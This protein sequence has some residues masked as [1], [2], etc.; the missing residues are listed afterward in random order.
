LSPL[1]NVTTIGDEFL[2]YCRGLNYVNLRGLSNVITIGSS[3]LDSCGAL[4]TLDLSSLS[5][6]TTIRDF[7]LL[8][9]NNL[10]TIKG[11]SHWKSITEIG[12]D[13]LGSIHDETDDVSITPD[14]GDVSIMPD[15]NDAP[16]PNLEDL[17]AGGRRAVNAIKTPEF[18]R[19][20]GALGGMSALRVAW[21]RAVVQAALARAGGGA[22]A[23]AGASAGAGAGAS[24]GSK[25]QRV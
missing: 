3:F 8:N 19:F 18:R 17:R 4:L 13:F 6:V 14:F 1:S 25:R 5:K 20:H 15:F 16:V 22:G 9:C 12:S 2:R 21:V 23:S 11:F 24:A 7:F 10:R